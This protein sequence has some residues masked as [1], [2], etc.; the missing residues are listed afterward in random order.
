M[1]F[2]TTRQKT[3]SQHVAS[4]PHD[5]SRR[6]V[7]RLVGLGLVAA[8]ATMI[9]ARAVR[10]RIFTGFIEDTALGGYDAVAYHT[11]GEA[12]RGSESITLSYQGA[13]WRFAT[14]ENLALFEANPAAYA[15]Q[16]GGHCAWAA[17]E[18][19]L[20]QG[21][22]NVWRIVD[23]RLYLNASQGINRRWLRDIPGFISQADANWPSL[24]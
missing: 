7:L 4:A 9:S 12:V 16:Y 17:A 10:A 2:Q 24:Q 15:P 11:T 21:D 8:T 23:G 13:T 6:G 22:P 18:G 14:A 20:A 3:S 19:Y 1:T 5:Y